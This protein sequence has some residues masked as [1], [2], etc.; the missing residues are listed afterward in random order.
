MSVEEAKGKGRRKDEAMEVGRFL[1]WLKRMDSDLYAYI[2]EICESENKKPTD[3]IRE[4]LKYA[5]LVRSA[6]SLTVEQLFQALHVW[7]ELHTWAMNTFL[8]LYEHFITR[9]I[10]SYATVLNAVKEQTEREERI[11]RMRVRSKML[12]IMR[13]VVTLLMANMV[14]PQ[15]R[16]ILQSSMSG[17]TPGKPQSKPELIVKRKE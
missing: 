2:Q 10:E 11:E 16:S 7:N 15:M 4:L 8:S 9:G 17:V 14:P 13:P 3:V 1:G 5:V 12:D 6:S